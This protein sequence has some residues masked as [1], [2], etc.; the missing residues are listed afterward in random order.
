MKAFAKFFLRGMIQN[1]LQYFLFNKIRLTTGKTCSVNSKLPSTIKPR[2]FTKKNMKN[3][4][5]NKERKL[6]IA[7]LYILI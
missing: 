7:I 2:N 6:I 4:L 5:N 3:S 1:A